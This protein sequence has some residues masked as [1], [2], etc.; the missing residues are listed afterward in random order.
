[1]DTDAV[2]IGAGVVGLALARALAVSGRRVTVIERETAIAQHASSRNSEVVHAGIYYEPGSLKATM[3][4]AGNRRLLAWCEA[5]GIPHR[6]IGKLIVAVSDGELDR[7]A[8]LQE[9]A[10][11]CG[12]ELAWWDSDRARGLEPLVRCAAAL[13]SPSTAIVDSHALCQ[14]LQRD[15]IDAGAAF[16]FGCA[17]ERATPIAGGLRV[18]AGGEHIDTHT[19]WI[20]AGSGAPA[21]ATRIEGMNS[22]AVPTARFAK[23]NY[24]ALQRNPGLRHLVYPLPQPGGLGI[25]VTLDLDDQVRLG[26]DVEWVDAP[27][28]YAVDPAR[29]DAFFASVQRWLPVLQRD[30]LRPAHAGIRAKIVGPGEPP[31]DFRIVGASE[32]GCAGVVALFGIES[33]GLTCCLELADAAIAAESDA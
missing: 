23:G 27:D 20:A 9:R 31:A 1:M 12:V 4:V 15:A 16:V 19:L 28:D 25:H 30:D 29:G 22:R 7:L 33:P 26:P 24:F 13:W 32:H 8:A 18:F 6:R 17:F 2:V 10:R 14:S 3:C 21:A 5:R 11:D